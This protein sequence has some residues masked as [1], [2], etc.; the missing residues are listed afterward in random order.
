[1]SIRCSNFYLNNYTEESPE[2]NNV[3]MCAETC[4]QQKI[5]NMSL[6]WAPCNELKDE[7]FSSYCTC[8][9]DCKMCF[10]PNSLPMVFERIVA[11]NMNY[12]DL[13]NNLAIN[14]RT[15]FE[16]VREEVTAIAWEKMVYEFINE[17]EHITQMDMSKHFVQLL[18]SLR[19]MQSKELF[20]LSPFIL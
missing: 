5:A 12:H 16:A 1:M 17:I 8:F 9:P 2:I 15:K 11:Y 4:I 14:C 7:A 3:M 10:T 18:P 20:K 19:S 6:G 13:V